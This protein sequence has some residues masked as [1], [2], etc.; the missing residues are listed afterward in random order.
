[1]S[2]LRR[3]EPSMTCPCNCS[4]CNHGADP[5]SLRR[6]VYSIRSLAE[7]RP[8]DFE[9]SAKTRLVRPILV[10]FFDMSV[11]LSDVQDMPRGAFN[12]QLSASTS[13]R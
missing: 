4:F 2:R 10:A 5:S 1:V 12:G 13:A 9:A 6:R 3:M 7:R 8:Q 11:L